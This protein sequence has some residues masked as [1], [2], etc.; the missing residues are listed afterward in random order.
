MTRLTLT[1]TPNNKITLTKPSN[2]LLDL[3]MNAYV[4]DF[5]LARFI[6]YVYH[7]TTSDV[8][9]AS[10]TS[11]VNLKGSIGYI[12]PGELNIYNWLTCS[13]CFS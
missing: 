3:E 6:I 12:A 9:P 4:S 7:T 13:T 11:L 5:G 2:V 10:S 8:V 1:Q